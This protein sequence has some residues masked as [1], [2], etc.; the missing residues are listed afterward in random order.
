MPINRPSTNPSSS[1]D[2]ESLENSHAN[3]SSEDSAEHPGEHPAEHSGEHSAERRPTLNTLPPL[4][5]S[6]HTP[7]SEATRGSDTSKGASKKRRFEGFAKN[8]CITCKGRILKCDGARPICGKCK[9]DGHLCIW[10][11]SR[12]PQQPIHQNPGDNNGAIGQ[13]GEIDVPRATS[14]RPSN[15]DSPVR[16][17]LSPA[18]AYDARRRPSQRLVRLNHSADP[19]RTCAG[20]CQ[21]TL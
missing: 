1:T 21:L 12:P 6:E 18:F 14:L 17:D 16:P 15:T 7:T 3:H 10:P 9:T 19:V 5:S 20:S 2:A 13:R 8:G 11:Q 4:R